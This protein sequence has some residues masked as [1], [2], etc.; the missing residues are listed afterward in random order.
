MIKEKLT[1][2]TEA[3]ET[4]K[5]KDINRNTRDQNKSETKSSQHLE[6]FLS[7]TK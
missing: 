2:Q 3:K 7:S 5:V 4:Y 1:N 6:N